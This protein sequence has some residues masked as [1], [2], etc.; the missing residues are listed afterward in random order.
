MQVQDVLYES[1]VINEW[2]EEV[3][4]QPPMLPEDPLFRARVGEGL[5]APYSM[6]I[7]IAMVE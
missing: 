4:Q 7:M 2:L 1:E 3:Y 6:A 5:L